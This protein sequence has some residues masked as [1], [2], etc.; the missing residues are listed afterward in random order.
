[1]IKLLDNP[2]TIR[3]DI[4]DCE[5]MSLPE[6]INDIGE[7]VKKQLTE[8]VK[9]K[10]KKCNIIILYSSYFESEPYDNIKGE[11]TG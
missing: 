7:E 1:M 2:V 11:V 4:N 9:Y 5:T 3:Y 8:D 6:L 10:P